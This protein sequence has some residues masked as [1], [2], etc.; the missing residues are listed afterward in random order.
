MAPRS[1]LGEFEQ[2]VLL[3]VLVRGNASSAI[4]IAAELE[5]RAGRTVSRGALYS[6]MERLEKKGLMEWEIDE[7]D[8][9]RSGHPRRH[10]SLTTSGISML[11]ETRET[12]TSFWGAADAFLAEER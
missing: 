9:A 3:A 1:T 11:K 6:T 8:I 4:A 5:E 7:G 2:L 12:L 10:F